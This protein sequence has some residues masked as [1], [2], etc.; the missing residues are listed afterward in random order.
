MPKTTSFWAV[1]YYKTRVKSGYSAGRTEDTQV[2]CER[3]R[4]GRGS[5]R[6]GRGAGAKARSVGSDARVGGAGPGRGL[7]L[8]LRL[9]GSVFFWVSGLGLRFYLFFFF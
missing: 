3:K 9:L 2:S 1:Y 6:G 7:G 4:S 5:G 8:G